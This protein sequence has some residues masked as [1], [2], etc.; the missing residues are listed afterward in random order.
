VYGAG[1]PSSGSSAILE[2]ARSFGVLLKQGWKPKRK[3]IF[4]SWDAEEHGL[5]GS[6]AF[7]E[8]N[9]YDLSQ[10]AVVYLNLDSG[11]RGFNFVA[12][13]TPSLR[14]AV[15]H[16]ASKV[17]Y[18]GNSGT[19][20]DNWNRNFDNLGSGSDFAPFVHHLGIACL[21]IEYS[22]ISA[23]VYHSLYDSFHW[24]ETFADPQFVYHKSIAQVLGLLALQFID[25]DILP[26]NYTTYV[27]KLQEYIK[28]TQNFIDRM[29]GSAQVEINSIESA[30]NILSDVVVKIEQEI[31]FLRE[32]PDPKAIMELNHRLVHTE[33]HFLAL[34][35]LPG[36]P[37]YK[38]QIQAPGM[39]T[40]YSYEPFPGL[41]Q[42]VRVGDWTLARQQVGSISSGIVNAAVYLSGTSPEP[43][44][45]K[46]NPIN[47]PLLV[48]IVVPVGCVI[49]IAIFVYIYRQRQNRMYSPVVDKS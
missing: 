13:G 5:V 3:I 39:Y 33:R 47:V 15:E 32:N 2:V 1:D 40:G 28:A 11:V 30:V 46:Q 45:S 34:E 49:L 41:S 37:W 9:A 48:G 43:A 17:Q 24:M 29:N 36:R 8:N 27:V 31:L 6:T 18:P 7:V 21:D 14:N 19:L 23:G 42:A 38:H 10:H 44:P 16:T 20:L 22:N 35:G 12:E 25:A 4:G 26:H